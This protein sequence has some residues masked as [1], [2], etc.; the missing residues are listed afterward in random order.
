LLKEWSL[1]GEEVG[2]VR[3]TETENIRHQATP[4][5]GSSNGKYSPPNLN[6]SYSTGKVG[7]VNFKHVPPVPSTYQRYQKK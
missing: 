4:A 7:G 2:N 3:K 1:I 5:Q 6:K